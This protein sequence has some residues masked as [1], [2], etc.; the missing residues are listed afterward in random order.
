MT[1]NTW[2]FWGYILYE[3]ANYASLIN[4]L[5]VIRNIKWNFIMQLFLATLFI[6]N[7]KWRLGSY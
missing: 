4:F 1:D 7:Y 5:F 6:L 2:F 3:A